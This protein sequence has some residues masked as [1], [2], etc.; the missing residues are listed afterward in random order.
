MSSD[1]KIHLSRDYNERK[2]QGHLRYTNRA[3]RMPVGWLWQVHRRQEHPLHLRKQL[4][5][6]YHL[7]WVQQSHRLHNWVKE[8]YGGWKYLTISFVIF[9]VYL[10]YIWGFSGGI[11][12]V[13]EQ[14]VQLSFCF[15]AISSFDS[16]TSS[17]IPLCETMDLKEVSV[18]LCVDT[19]D[20]RTH[21]S[22]Y[23]AFAR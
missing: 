2:L 19:L 18:V 6:A 14:N 1:C 15:T 9:T 13:I 16:M 8:W 23:V 10:C 22:E 12:G 3:G 7:V 21:S 5:S 11:S 4:W 17:G 20:T